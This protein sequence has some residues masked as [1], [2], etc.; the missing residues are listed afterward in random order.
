MGF[1]PPMQ[2]PTCTGIS[3]G[4]FLFFLHNEDQMQVRLTSCTALSICCARTHALLRTLTI[5][6]ERLR[7]FACGSDCCGLGESG[8]ASGIELSSEITVLGWPW[9]SDG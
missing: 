4:P 2:M 6:R 8:I 9:T 3:N 1:Q 7:Q 5:D